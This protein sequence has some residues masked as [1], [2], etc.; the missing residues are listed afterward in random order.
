MAKQISLFGSEPAEKLR[1][2]EVNQV[3]Q[4]EGYDYDKYVVYEIPDGESGWCYKLINLRTKEFSCTNSIRPLNTKFGIGF[5]YDSENPKFMDSVEVAMLLQE[6]EAKKKADTEE[7]EREKQHIEQVSEIGRRRLEE[8]LSENAQAII[9]AR[10]KQ[11]ESDSMTD[12]FAHSTKRTVI[13]GFS[14]HKRNLFSEMRKYASNFEGTAYLA[15]QNKDYEHRENYS[16]GNGYYLGESKY[17]GWIIE[18]VAI[19]NRQSTIESFAYIAGD[20]SNIRI[21]NDSSNTPKGDTHKSDCMVV[22]YSQKALA[23]LGD[24]KPIKTQLKALG[25][26]FNSRLTYQGERVAGWIFSKSN[27]QELAVFF[28]LD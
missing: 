10:L 24:T 17:D 4:M 8:I 6:A 25:G 7:A 1:S 23:V 5:Y 20:E 16:M 3:I 13:L 26:R 18:K 15:Q 28:G 27:E 12:Y 21:S 22:E 2:V 9:V 11:D 14:K 19:H